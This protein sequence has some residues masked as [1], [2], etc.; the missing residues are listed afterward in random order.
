MQ[1]DP[2]ES[3]TENRNIYTV[4]II[5]RH[6]NIPCY[7]NSL[8]QNTRISTLDRVNI[9][10][11]IKIQSN[12]V[13]FWKII[14]LVSKELYYHLQAL[15]S[16]VV[17]S[18]CG[19]NKSHTNSAPISNPSSPQLSTSNQCLLTTN[20]DVHIDQISSMWMAWAG[21]FTSI[22]LDNIWRLHLIQFHTRTN[23][24]SVHNR[25][26]EQLNRASGWPNTDSD[27]RK[28]FDIIVICEFMKSAV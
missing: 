21:H 2:A 25:S 16:V 15:L 13:N 22:W 14:M 11:A 5:S 7:I 23:A 6:K 4:H 24:M 9:M 17:I 26:I 1:I 19:F 28:L 12:M 27:F 10:A 8:L 20:P 18:T 3:F